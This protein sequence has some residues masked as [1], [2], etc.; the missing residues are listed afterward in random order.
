MAEDPGQKQSGGS[1][2]RLAG[3]ELAIFNRQL[4]SMVATH[5]PLAPAL[6][7]LSRDI[8]K[9]AIRRSLEEL[10]RSVEAGASLSEALR[11]HGRFLPPLYV[12]LIEAGEKSGNLA[13]ALNQIAE[14]SQKMASFRARMWEMFTYPIV[15]LCVAAL[16]FLCICYFIVPT[17][18]EMFTGLGGGASLPQPTRLVIGVSDFLRAY[19]PIIL[20]VAA[21][22]VTAAIFIWRAAPVRR[23]R[24]AVSLYFP[25]L[26]R[27]MRAAYTAQLAQTLGA[28]LRS[29]MMLPRALELAAGTCRNSIMEKSIM[30]LRREVASGKKLSEAMFEYRVIP[31]S[32][33]WMVSAG[34][35]GGNLDE[36][37]FEL[38]R[39]YSDEAD[40]FMSTIFLLA[41]PLLF[42]LMGLFVGLVL[43]S[44]FL[45]LIQLGGLIE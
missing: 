27:F 14:H 9:P 7:A 32:L 1:R 8:R 30:K 5:L 40:H 3:L 22:L 15:V 42:I 2:G 29:G 6:R 12:S 34:E 44:L 33:A 18:A 41:E 38:S 23:V 43:I 4:A 21:A 13:E 45:P 35:Q 24:D 36:S 25:L 20:L 16:I 37:L 17:F 11:M 39:F 10:C 26:G 19:L 31:Y 28:L